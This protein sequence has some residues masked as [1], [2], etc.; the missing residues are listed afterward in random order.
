MSQGGRACGNGK[1]PKKKPFK[2]SGGER[3]FARKFLISVVGNYFFLA[4]GLAAGF[5]LAGAMVRKLKEY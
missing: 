2:A 4:A 5:F 1:N 3:L